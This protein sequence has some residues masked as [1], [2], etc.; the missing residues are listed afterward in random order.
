MGEWVPQEGALLLGVW[1]LQIQGGLIYFNLLQW[2]S[3]IQEDWEFGAFR[4]CNGVSNGTPLPQLTLRLEAEEAEEAEEARGDPAGYL[5]QRL[6]LREHFTEVPPT[7]ETRTYPPG[8]GRLLSWLVTTVR[9]RDRLARLRVNI[10][11]KNKMRAATNFK[12]KK[13]FLVHLKKSLL[14]K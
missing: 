10:K 13:D 7:N 5:G 2:F 11:L 14:E 6:R 12:T 9:D 8:G 1:I 3:S 4:D